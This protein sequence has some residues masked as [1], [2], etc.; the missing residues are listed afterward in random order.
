M[1]MKVRTKGKFKAAFNSLLYE[2]T[3]VLT[4]VSHF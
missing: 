1:K 2:N 3:A 4:L